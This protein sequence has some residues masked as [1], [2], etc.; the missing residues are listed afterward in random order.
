MLTKYEISNILINHFYHD[1]FING[2]GIGIYVYIYTVSIPASFEINKT[3][4][5]LF[6]NTED[7]KQIKIQI[8]GKIK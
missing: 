1:N 8:I 5:K 7:R 4:E 3:L 2:M 6:M